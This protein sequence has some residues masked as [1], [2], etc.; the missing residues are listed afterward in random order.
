M[1]GSLLTPASVR[2]R[3]QGFANAHRKPHLLA[4]AIVVL[5]RL[6]FGP[7][8]WTPPDTTDA[9]CGWAGVLLVFAGIVGRT[10]ATLST[11]GLKDAGVI[12]TELYSVCRNPLCFPSFLVVFGLGLVSRRPDFLLL[13]CA[14]FFAVFIP[15]MHN[16]AKSLRARFAEFAAHEAGVPL[17]F[18]NFRLW[19]DRPS[20]E[21]RFRLVKR[22]LLDSSLALVTIPT[23]TLAS[24]QPQPARRKAFAQPTPRP[25]QIES[26]RPVESPQLRLTEQSL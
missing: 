20:W 5:A 3:Q 14:A 9:A 10:L 6:H 7:S 13:V 11:G 4:L 25:T 19:Q 16:E 22:T 18:P 17:F 21:I 23:I 26:S 12:R 15:M 24:H 8:P 2:L 1:I